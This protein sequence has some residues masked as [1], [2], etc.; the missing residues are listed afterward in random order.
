MNLWQKLKLSAAILL[1]NVFGHFRA[2][3]WTPFRSTRR[4][5]PQDARFNVTQSSRTIIAEKAKD[6]ED[7]NAV[8]Q[9][10][11]EVFVNYTVGPQGL[12]LIPNSTDKNW[13][14]AAKIYWNNT[15]NFIDLKSRQNFG[16]L[17]SLIA[18]RWCFDGE[19]FIL[20]TRGVAADG[21]TYPRIQL[22][23]YHLV[24]TPPE[25]ARDEGK[26]IVDGVEIDSNGR[27][28][29]YWVKDSSVSTVFRFIDAKDMIHVFEPT[30]PGQY[31]GMS[32]FHAAINYLERLDDLQ[33]L[34]FRAVTDAAEKSTFVKTATGQMPIGMSGGGMPGDGF[35]I[36]APVAGQSLSARSDELRESIGG[37]TVAL[38][39]NEDVSQFTPVR[40]TESTRYLWSYLTSCTCSAFGIPKLVCFS[41]WL[42]KPQG[43]VVRGDYDIAAQFFRSRS[44]VIAASCREVYIYVMGWGIR[45]D[46]SIADK[47]GD[48]S[49]VN[50]TIRPPRAVNVD[51]GRNASADI[52][53]LAAGTTNYDLLYA[54]QGLDWQEELTKLADQVKFVN[55]LAAKRGL[56]PA[57]IREQAAIV[58]SKAKEALAAETTRQQQEDTLA[59]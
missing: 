57:E 44:A 5:H 42:D 20:K 28:T 52:A 18:W 56:Q 48:G 11:G 59:S 24:S 1:P 36:N 58:L 54:P 53:G 50:V 9:R 27:P 34:E 14:D 25:R 45:T 22:I 40:P 47:P 43:T 4:S 49:W 30:R 10:L 26:T 21:R 33:E 29:G 13:N 17:Q 55:D 35:S 3:E 32:F 46:S 2:T 23:E 39:L 31:R 37:R 12:V 8:A 16:C 38:G 19:I 41:E 6:F 15:A 7:N 51:V